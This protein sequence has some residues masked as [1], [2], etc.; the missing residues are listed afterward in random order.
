MRKLGWGGALH[1]RPIQ[2][3]GEFEGGGG[4]GGLLHST[5]L[6]RIKTHFRSIEKVDGCCP[7]Q[8][9]FDYMIPIV[10]LFIMVTGDFP[11]GGW[12]GGGVIQPHQP[13]LPPW[14]RS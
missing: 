1:I 8:L 14:L 12:G 4:G 2:R 3:F 5:N 10:I 13:P 6:T 9:A 7:D 11:L